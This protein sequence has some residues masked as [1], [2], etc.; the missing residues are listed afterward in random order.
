MTQDAAA[1]DVGQSNAPEVRPADVRDAVV[2]R[3]PLVHEGVVGG[4]QL[5]HAAIVAEDA[6]GEQLGFAAEPLPQVFVEVGVLSRIRQYRRKVAQEQPLPDKVIDDGISSRVGEHTP[7]L[8]L[9]HPRFCEAFPTPRHPA[10]RRQECCST[11]K[12]TDVKRAPDR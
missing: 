2:V 1:I 10:A 3:Q 6:A 4:E 9:E 8:P 5:E 7:H 11:G 12:T